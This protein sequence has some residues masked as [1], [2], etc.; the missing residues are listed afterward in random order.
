[1]PSFPSCVVYFSICLSSVNA[2]SSSACFSCAAQVSGG[3]EEAQ[4]ADGVKPGEGKI[5]I[6]LILIPERKTGRNRGMKEERREETETGRQRGMKE[7]KEEKGRK[8][9]RKEGKK[10]R[11]Q[12][13]R[14]E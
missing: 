3:E 4:I 12:E 9:S 10:R 8:E 13:Q 7:E 2:A 11:K 1:M 14:K 5:K 6:L